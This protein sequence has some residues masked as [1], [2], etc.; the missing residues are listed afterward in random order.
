MTDITGIGSVA[1]FFGKVID[2]IFPD[3]TQAAAA[4]AALAS[5]EQSGELQLLIEQIKTNQ[6]EAQ[7]TNWLVAGWRPFTGWICAVSFGYA[8]IIAPILHLTI[9]DV[10]LMSQVLLGMLGLAGMRSYEKKNGAEGNR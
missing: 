9:P 8:T 2:K 4:R 1:D 10:S 3:A 6:I 7:S 5:A